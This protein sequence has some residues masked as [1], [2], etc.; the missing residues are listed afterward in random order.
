MLSFQAQHLVHLHDD[1]DGVD[2]D[3]SSS[4]YQ[5]ENGT[6]LSIRDSYEGLVRRTSCMMQSIM[7]MY[8]TA[9]KQQTSAQES[10]S[11]SLSSRTM[12]TVPT[13]AKTTASSSSSTASPPARDDYSLRVDDLVVEGLDH[14]CDWSL[15]PYV[16][17]S[18]REQ[19]RSLIIPTT[20]TSSIT[21]NNIAIPISNTVTTTSTSTTSYEIIEEDIKSAIWYFRSAVN[22][23]KYIHLDNKMIMISS[24]SGSGSQ[25]RR[26]HC[27]DYDRYRIDN[28]CCHSDTSSIDRCDV[29]HDNTMK[30]NELLQKKRL[31]RLWSIICPHI[32]AYCKERL[33]QLSYRL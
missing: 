31:S 20:I 9:P 27:D 16:L 22:P 12:S 3:S 25:H 24:G 5:Q 14:H 1:D 10:V 18:C 19:L 4:H 7:S 15:L 30:S 6:H 28:S 17:Q 2:D 29:I 21:T 8:A 26:G 23:R 32:N 13:P 11:S 33:K